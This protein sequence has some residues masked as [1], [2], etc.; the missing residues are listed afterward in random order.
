[1]NSK[2]ILIICLGGNQICT[3]IVDCALRNNYISNQTRIILENYEAKWPKRMKMQT[4]DM[5]IA[6]EVCHIPADAIPTSLQCAF[7]TKDATK[8]LILLRYVLGVH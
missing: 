2:V 6:H 3:R 7:A 4:V 8:E 1:V 5:S